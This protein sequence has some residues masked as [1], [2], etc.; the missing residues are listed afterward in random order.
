[1]ER[2]VAIKVI[3]K[4]LILAAGVVERFHREVKAAARLAHP[5]VVQAFDAEKA[6]ELHFLVLEFIDGV[7]LEALVKRDGPLPVEQAC[8]YVRQAALGLAHA[9]AQGLVHR[10]IKPQ[11][12]MV[13]PQG[14]VKVMDFGLAS[15]NAERA[16]EGGL[17][18]LGQGLGTP[19]YMAPEQIRDA[20]SADAR[21]DIYSLGCTL[22]FLLT[23]RPPFPQ[24]N[25]TQKFAA[26][27][28]LQPERLSALCP[29]LPAGL[30]QI[31]DKM[32]AKDPTHRY[33]TAAAVVAAVE[34]FCGPSKAKPPQRGWWRWTMGAAALMAVAVALGGVVVIL[35][36]GSGHRVPDK[37]GRSDSK[38]LKLPD[39]LATLEPVFDD[40]FRDPAVSPFD[41]TRGRKHFFWHHEELK[42]DFYFDRGLVNWFQPISGGLDSNRCQVKDHDAGLFLE[43]ACRVTAKLLTWPE[44]DR[45]CWMLLLGS[46]TR[47]GHHIAVMVW[48]NG[49]LE[50]GPSAWKEANFPL[51][52]GKRMRPAALHPAGEANTLLVALQGRTLSIWVNNAPACDPITL[53][54]DMP[55]MNQSVGMWQFPRGGEVRGEFSRFTLWQLPPAETK[56]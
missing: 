30:V 18:E 36:P 20:R 44:S 26:H 19:D 47:K 14:Q 9:A 32:M 52:R 49:D 35:L 8:D 31:I 48:N 53:E 34:P 15:I 11:N 46:E 25:A 39:D 24:G 17:T 45:V 13:T 55:P 33:Q 41:P 7:T 1:M 28:E 6:G 54:K 40:N 2:T 37:P 16:G 51:P 43:F 56:P 29:E 5:N 42:S 12:I 3:N 4:E 38:V 27:L 50:V 23:G 22:Y 21:A 10:D